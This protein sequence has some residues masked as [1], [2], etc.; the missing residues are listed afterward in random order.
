MTAPPP[1]PHSPRTF[2]FL[3]I[4]LRSN[5]PALVAAAAVIGVGVALC[6]TAMT[7]F[8][9]LA[10]V[11][12]FGLPFD[13]R[14]S[15]ADK[16]APLAAFLSLG[17]GGL[18]LGSIAAW[19]Q[20]H[21]KPPA[22]DPIEANALHGGRMSL[23]DS[24][25][26]SVQTTLS[27][28][29]GAS[30]GLEAGYTQIG[31]GIGSKFGQIFGL[32]RRDLRLL[33]AAGTAAAIGGSFGAP[34]T[35]AFYAFE[36]ILGTYSI[37][38][39]GPIFS[40]SIVGVL[41]TRALSGAPYQLHIPPVPAL[42]LA[43]YPALILLGAFAAALG[44]TA[45]R[46]ASAAESAFKKTRTPIWAR[47]VL[48][49]MVVAAL[50]VATPQALGA[51]HG[52]LALDIRMDLP[53]RTLAFLLAVKMI[54]CMTSL[55]SGFRGGLF[56]AS[57]VMGA[58]LGKLFCAVATMALPGI[59]LD[60]T[61]CALTGMATL[62]VAI[63]GGPLTMS[64]LVLENSSEFSVTAA[65]LTAAI[66]ASIIVRATFGYSFS[67]W[68]LHLRGEN[69]RS[70]N[71]IGWIRELTVG[72]LMRRSPPLADEN[73][74]IKALCA[75]YPLGSEQTIAVT[76]DKGRYAGLVS[77][78][79]AHRIAQ[80]T[81]EPRRLGDIAHFGA[82]YLTESMNAKL[83]MTAFD[84]AQTDQLAVIDPTTMKPMGL[85]TEAYI[86]RRYGEAADEA[87]RGILGI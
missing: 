52:A 37:A 81:S 26:V 20:K 82:I 43:H 31:A 65:I 36:L 59:D 35:G 30:V 74:D 62:G 16:I 13:V 1:A 45:M 53:A 66:G 58:L 80:Q 76:G 22:V 79:E 47:P 9:N 87:A 38:A 17:L 27:N 54:A 33:L 57:L 73:S 49:G 6:V 83:A 21:K 34:L 71:D 14:L 3:R 55:G 64:F 67:T 41:T 12:I 48:G 29:C 10:H 46:A 51:G 25:L 7:Q 19:R 5:E 28:A 11:L 61:I 86:A 69:I 70:A 2:R 85:L 39:A 78:A 32:R 75:A 60:S 42:P 84:Q 23:R 24:L 4:L 77:L 18:L 68:R 56:F 63:V 72:R 8:A 40:A 15:A 44:V 50:A